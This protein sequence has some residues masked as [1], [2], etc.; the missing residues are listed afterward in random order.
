M[1]VAIREI[2]EERREDINIPNE[3]FPLRGR[4]IPALTDGVW[5]HTFVSLPREERGEMTFPDENYDFSEMSKD[6][7]FVGAYDGDVCVGLAIYQKQLFGY[8]YL[9]DL[10]VCRR[11]RR[12]GVGSL[13]IEYGERLAK[14]YGLRGIYAVCQDNNQGACRFY[15]KNGFEIGGFNN[16]VYAGTKQESKGDIYFYR[17]LPE[18]ERGANGV[19]KEKLM[20][21]NTKRP[22]RREDWKTKPMPEKHETFVLTRKL[23][24]KEMNAL[25][26]GN[27]PREMEDKWFWYMEGDTLFAHR[28]WTGTLIFRV[29]FREDGNH[30]VT[31]NRDPEQ[32]GGDSVEEDLESLNSLLDWWTE[33]PYDH[34]GEWISETADALKKTGKRKK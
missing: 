3:P 6:C 17:D 32:Y 18:H 10:K 2:N 24:E 14:K 25:R 29:D 11:Y 23:S 22:A 31:V 33:S 34:Y 30:V 28:S 27:V 19:R 4:M 8:L 12:A 21:E 26:F 7:V 20:T 1:T 16:R 5:S 9:Y 15:L 13:L